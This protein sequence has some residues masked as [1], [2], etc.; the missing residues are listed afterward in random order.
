[1]IEHLRL[2]HPSFSLFSPLTPPPNPPRLRNRCR[3]DVATRSQH[4][5]V[6]V[7]GAVARQ[8]RPRFWVAC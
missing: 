2:V 1:M 3:N 4:I 5:V 6:L 8:T 7:G